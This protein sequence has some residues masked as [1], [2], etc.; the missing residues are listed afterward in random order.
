MF[1]HPSFQVILFHDGEIY[2]NISLFHIISRFV[3]Y[4]DRSINIYLFHKLCH[5]AR[6]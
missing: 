2:S 3:Y 5:C 4:V 6:E 1:D